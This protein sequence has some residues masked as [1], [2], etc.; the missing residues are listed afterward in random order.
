M[1]CIF[2]LVVCM[3]YYGLALNSGDLGG[4]RFLNFFLQTVMDIPGRLLVLV[5]V[6]RVGRKPIQVGSMVIGGVACLSTIFSIIYGGKG[7]FFSV[8]AILARLSKV[9]RI[10]MCDIFTLTCVCVL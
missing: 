6:D 3:V 4:D 10:R 8:R 1:L 5:L 7:N 9:L 2:R